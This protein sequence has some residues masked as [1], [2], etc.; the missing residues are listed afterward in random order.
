MDEKREFL[1]HTLATLAYRATRALEGSPES[2]AVFEGTGKRPDQI[3]AHMG[4]LFDWALSITEGRETWHNSTPL[5]WAEEQKRFFR[6]LAAFD[7]YLASDAPLH[8][9]VERLFQGPVA[10]ALTHV[11]QL[12]MM[13]RLAGCQSWGENFYVADVTVGQVSSSQPEPVKRFK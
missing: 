6:A 7:A 3:L 5:A 12:A 2:F 4:D 8:A 11:G 13:R 10:D 9:P 1:R